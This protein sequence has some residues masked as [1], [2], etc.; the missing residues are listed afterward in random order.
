MYILYFFYKAKTKDIKNLVFFFN[1]LQTLS[2]KKNKKTK[3]QMKSLGSRFFVVAF[4]LHLFLL[5]LPKQPEFGII[6][7]FLLALSF[8]FDLFKNKK[9]RNSSL[10]SFLQELICK[11]WPGN[12]GK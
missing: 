6:A 12:E 11:F 9:V 3:K 5:A 8:C 10:V 1:T 4:R 2:R 7:L